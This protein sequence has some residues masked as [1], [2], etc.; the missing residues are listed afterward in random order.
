MSQS[1][2]KNFDYTYYTINDSNS[3]EGISLYAAIGEILVPKAIIRGGKEESLFINTK[4]RQQMKLKA[5]KH[6]ILFCIL[7]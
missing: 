6:T 2:S 7:S 1:K 5:S 3:S 4:I